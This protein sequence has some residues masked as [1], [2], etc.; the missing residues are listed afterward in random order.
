M[1]KELDEIFEREWNDACDKSMQGLTFSLAAATY[2]FNVGAAFQQ[3]R[4]LSIIN[5]YYY[6]CITDRLFECITDRIRGE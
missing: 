1:N 5:D 2:W 6:E 3:T 4:I